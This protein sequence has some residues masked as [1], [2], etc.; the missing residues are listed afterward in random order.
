MN[1]LQRLLIYSALL[2][3]FSSCKNE[4]DVNAPWKETTVVYGLLSPTDS[5]QY[6]KINKAFLG[7]GNE[8]SYAKIADS[9]NYPDILKVTIQR[10]KKDGTKE[11]PVQL[12]RDMSIQ[13]D[14]GIFMSDAGT[15]VLYKWLTPTGTIDKENQYLLT[16]INTQS[17]K[18]VTGFTSIVGDISSPNTPTVPW[19]SKTLTLTNHPNNNVKIGWGTA[20]SGKIYNLVIRIFY[21]EKDLS[22]NSFFPKYLDWAFGNQEALDTLGSNGNP[23][24]SLEQ[25]FEGDQFYQYVANKLADMPSGSRH[26]DSISFIWS[27]GTLDLDTYIQVYQPSIGIVQEKPQYTNLNGGI[28]IFSSRSTYTVHGCKLNQNSQDTLILGPMT[29]SKGFF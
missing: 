17:G 4:L 9:V 7:P 15:N 11:S 25:D 2:G 13:K 6:I 23:G 10:F 19:S 22:T 21:K 16:I 27:V 28:G 24:E 18:M 20:A 26:L 14:T 3:A 8:L 5:V 1:Y 29:A 12:I